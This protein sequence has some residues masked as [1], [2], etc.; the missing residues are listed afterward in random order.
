MPAGRGRRQTKRGFDE[1][2]RLEPVVAQ[3]VDVRVGERVGVVRQSTGLLEELADGDGAPV[4]AAAL[5]QAR[6]M[7]R[8]GGVQREPPL[9]GELEDDGGGERLGDTADAEPVPG[10]RRPPGPHVGDAAGPGPR[11]AGGIDDLGDGSGQAVL[12]GQAVQRALQCLMV[13]A[14]GAGGRCGGSPCPGHERDGDGAGEGG[15]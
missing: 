1:F 4:V 7:V 8:H 3:P 11:A 15:E 10:T 13:V 5:D 6:K 9:G 2:P 12:A 14:G